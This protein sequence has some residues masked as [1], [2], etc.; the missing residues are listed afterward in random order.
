MLK[1]IALGKVEVCING[2]PLQGRVDERR[3]LLLIY[4]AEMG[5]Q[6]SRQRVAQLLWP[7]VSSN[8]ALTS[9]RTLMTRMR[10]EG[11]APYLLSER[12]SI[13]LHPKA[14][15]YY[16]L[17][18]LRKLLH[19]LEQTSIHNLLAATTLF[20]GAFMAGLLFAEFPELAEW[21]D[22]LQYELEM[23]M[24]RAYYRLIPL[25]IQQQETAQAVHLGKRLIDLASYED[26]A[27]LLYLQALASAGRVAEA[28]RHFYAYQRTIREELPGASISLELEAFVTQLTQPGHAMRLMASTA[29]AKLPVAASS[30][31]A[32]QPLSYLNPTHVLV[33]REQEQKNLFALLASNH[34]LISLVGLGGAGKTFFILSQINTL[35]T[36]FP[37]GLYFVDLRKI[38]RENESIANE[39]LSAIG[40]TLQIRREVGQSLLAQIADKLGNGV[41][42]LILDNFEVVQTATHVVLELLQAIPLLTVIVTSRQRLNL[43]S[44]VILPMMGLPVVFNGTKDNKVQEADAV[45]FFSL[46]AQRIS[47]NFAIHDTNRAA[48]VTLCQQLGGLPLAIDLAAK[49]L[50]FYS[51]DELIAATADGDT[52]LL[53]ADHKDLSSD[54][55]SMERVLS[56]M[57]Q[58]LSGEAKRVLAQ[59]S[60]FSNVWHR[61]AML[62]V[63]P[64]PRILYNELINASLLQVE[65]SGWF[66]LHPL[67]KQFAQ[68]R[69]T[70]VDEVSLRHAIHFLGLLNL[71]ERMFEFGR[72]REPGVFEMLQMRLQDLI[73]AWQWAVKHHTWELLATAIVSMNHLF[74]IAVQFSELAFLFRPLLHELPPE[75]MRT[76]LEQRLAG[77][78]AIALAHVQI[79]IGSNPQDVDWLEQGIKWLEQ[80]GTPFEKV[81]AYILY[82]RAQT[83][84]YGD[85]NRAVELLGKAVDLA[86]KHQ[87]TD[88]HAQALIQIAFC[89]SRDGKWAESKRFIEEA[90]AQAYASNLVSPIVL[91]EACLL[92]TSIG[93]YERAEIVLNEF[94]NRIDDTRKRLWET[95]NVFNRCKLLMAHKRSDEAIVILEQ[96]FTL[97][98]PQ[99]PVNVVYG[100]AILASCHAQQGNF[101]SALH[102]ALT[103]L[104]DSEK[105]G[106]VQHIMFTRLILAQMQILA[107]QTENTLPMLYDLLRSALASRGVTLIFSALYL[108]VVLR[109]FELPEELYLRIVKIAAVSPILEFLLQPLARSYLYS[110]GIVFEPAE[111]EELWAADRKM[112]MAL[113]TEVAEKLQI[114]TE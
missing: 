18:E 33:G 15:V 101:R 97:N 107:N 111:K 114:K 87:F 108:I 40:L 95:T 45:A 43:S 59:L 12:E 25:L 49:Q 27:Q 53:A 72:M 70:A 105:T 88:M 94:E 34:R 56:G 48:V 100:K 68:P 104:H 66:S 93:E 7:Q 39:L 60:I 32:E 110:Q 16:D 17:G 54:H 2:K 30:S 24:T 28:M 73:Q 74:V 80:A 50:D 29:F 78:A 64:A 112:T 51:L 91:N 9:L 42:C 41:C 86:G 10:R 62:T 99:L 20:R 79:Q 81:I 89:K 83:Q 11:F 26:Q 75:P 67:V 46:C 96:A 61:D 69:L 106:S 57:W 14:D 76:P 47:P 55:H 102:N 35:R 113:V 4:L 1:L 23:L 52:S 58:T 22:S 21:V 8:L 90:E 19:N 5:Q 82:G 6:E 63:V 92:Y 109:S 65:E 98:E 36:L 85:V 103:S 31:Q 38:S 71:D 84:S 37:D 13:G 77:Q 44:E 3:A